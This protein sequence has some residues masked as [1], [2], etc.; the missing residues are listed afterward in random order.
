MESEIGNQRMTDE[1]LNGRIK[2]LSKV[3]SGFLEADLDE[4]RLTSNP[5]L[6]EEIRVLLE[7]NLWMGNIDPYDPHWSFR[8]D[9]HDVAE[10]NPEIPWKEVREADLK[11]GAGTILFYHGLLKGFWDQFKTKV[12]MTQEERASQPFY[13]W[14]SYIK[15]DIPRDMQQFCSF[16][17][18]VHFFR[19]GLDAIPALMS[20][21][22][23]MPIDIFR[24][25]K[26]PGCGKC[27]VITSKHQR[28]YCN[29]NCASK[30]EQQIKR[31]ADPAGFNQYYRNYRQKKKL[32][33]KEE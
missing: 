15:L 33:R 16:G 23:E 27:F 24:K 10:D 19:G 30:H 22:Q 2:Q 8:S 6:I 26:N 25:C 31:Q 28:E 4:Q 1:Q 3:V 32:E 18:T 7:G 5:D 9:L 14:D 21:L 17:K 11:E 12:F 20:Q 13:G 29:R